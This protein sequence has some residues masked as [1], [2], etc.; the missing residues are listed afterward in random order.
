MLV[1]EGEETRNV[2]GTPSFPFIS[3]VQNDGRHFILSLSSS[4]EGSRRIP[5]VLGLIQKLKLRSGGRSYCTN[6]IF[7]L[8]GLD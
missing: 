8:Y 3:R 4:A 6:K 7:Y 1:C 2:V 5:S